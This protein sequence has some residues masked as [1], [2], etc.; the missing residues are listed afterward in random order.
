MSSHMAWQEHS[1]SS[2][3]ELNTAA[4]GSIHFFSETA[5]ALNNKSNGTL[6]TLDLLQPDSSHMHARL[7]SM[8][9]SQLAHLDQQPILALQQFDFVQLLSLTDKDQS[10]C[11]T[12]AECGATKLDAHDCV[13]VLADHAT[14]IATLD[15][16]LNVQI[17]QLTPDDAGRLSAKKVDNLDSSRGIDVQLHPLSWGTIA[18]SPV[19]LLQSVDDGQFYVWRGATQAVRSLD[20]SLTAF[21]HT[22]LWLCRGILFVSCVAFAF[23]PLV[24]E[25]VSIF[26]RCGAGAT[27]NAPRHSLFC[28]LCERSD[29]LL[30]SRHGHDST[31]AVHV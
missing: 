30:C 7:G 28:C 21:R 8:W 23:V 10:K 19:L 6:S 20:S 17:H 12:I 16:D 26:G 11:G 14:M 31:V 1:F 9:H 29:S 24:E 27:C 13:F 4:W 3:N 5:F 2:E 22:P 18:G 25:D 15:E